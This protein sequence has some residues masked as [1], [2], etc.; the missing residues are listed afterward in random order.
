MTN[1]GEGGG[2]GA[3]GFDLGACGEGYEGVAG[4]WLVGWWLWRER[5]DVKVMER[6]PPPAPAR[7]CAMLSLCW[8]MGVGEVD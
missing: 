5:T 1:G 4:G 7:A 3:F 8:M 6:R 2:A